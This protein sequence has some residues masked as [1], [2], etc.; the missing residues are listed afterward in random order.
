MA[1][2]LLEIKRKIVNVQKIGQITKA[3]EMVARVKFK[4]LMQKATQA[5]PYFDALSHLLANHAG[6]TEFS[7]PLLVAGD[8]HRVAI[9]ILTSD[10]GMCGSFNSMLFKKI[11]PLLEQHEGDTIFIYC[12]GRKGIKQYKTRGYNVHKSMMGIWARLAFTH[13][14]EIADDLETLWTQER[15]G[16]VYLAWNQFQSGGKSAATVVQLLPMSGPEAE[17]D[18]SGFHDWYIYEP[19]AKSILG[20]L[21]PRYLRQVLYQSLIESTTAEEKSRMEAMN[22]ATS[23]TKKMAEE[24]TLEANR[25]RQTAITLELADIVGGAE[26]LSE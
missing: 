8:P 7:H 10:R 26:G 17:A 25:V 21:L 6:G 15:L 11:A 23:E 19:D 2:K 22:R 1:G 24:L 14:E 9:L 12:V 4:R 20:F 16:K 18:S 13:A 5:R 3:M